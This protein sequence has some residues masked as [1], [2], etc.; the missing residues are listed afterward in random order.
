MTCV[1]I[2]S[3]RLTLENREIFEQVML[4][5]MSNERYDRFAFY[6]HIL[7]Q[8]NVTIDDNYPHMAGVGFKNYN[9]NLIINS[10]LFSTVPMDTQVG[11]LVHES[12]HVFFE[13]LQ[14]KGD[15]NH[16]RYNIAADCAI[17]QLIGREFVG[18]GIFPEDLK[19]PY[20]LSAEQYYEFT[21]TSTTHEVYGGHEEWGDVDES[22]YELMDGI[23]S[24]IIDT[25]VSCD[26]GKVPEYVH[27]YINLNKS[28]S[29]IQW[30]SVLYNIIGSK[31]SDRDLTIMRPN[32]RQSSRLELKG[33][34][35]GTDTPNVLCI[36][37]VSGSM[38]DSA[39]SRG[40]N[41]INSV[42]KMFD[43]DLNL[44]QV[45]TKV[46]NIE[47]FNIKTKLLKRRGN[48]GTLIYSAIDYIIT[49]KISS[50]VIVIITDGHIE[51]VS[52][53]PIKPKCKV[54]FLVTDKVTI[55][56]VEVVKNFSQ[57]NI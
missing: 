3:R 49:N 35:R 1:I 6:G 45:D 19:A 54:V 53:W 55:P 13:H 23:C 27:N 32:R 42:C 24:G 17:N 57:F 5:I 9:Y 7:T 50:D 40:L 56:G 36:T 8:C 47:K 21:S 28:S 12:M 39:V 52:S 37:D 22:D 38:K 11:I 41:E 33:K 18:L 4:N 2:Y 30:K 25:A 14:R 29:K 34:R 51:D 26:P 44:I 31:D 46:H 15:R 20:N 43:T 16:E 10:R 48:G